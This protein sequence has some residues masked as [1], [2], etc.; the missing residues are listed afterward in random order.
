MPFSDFRI[1]GWPSAYS[2]GTK[3]LYYTRIIYVQY[4]LRI[5]LENSHPNNATGLRLVS[6][7]SLFLVNPSKGAPAMLWWSTRVQFINYVCNSLC[8]QY[9]GISMWI[10]ITGW[11]V[12]GW[13]DHRRVITSVLVSRMLVIVSML[14]KVLII[15]NEHFWTYT[16]I[17]VSS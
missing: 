4:L 8:M 9:F 17:C 6:I 11:T 2:I 5:P 7:A 15:N 3:V 16:Y 1:K 10:A 13:Y 14:A 12:K